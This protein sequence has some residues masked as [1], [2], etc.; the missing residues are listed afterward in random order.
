MS[1][2]FSDQLN[3]SPIRFDIFLTSL[4]NSSSPLEPK[5]TCGDGLPLLLE[6]GGRIANIRYNQIVH[7]GLM[8]Y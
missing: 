4:S 2:W 5:K 1:V 8:I 7:W 6:G 3:S